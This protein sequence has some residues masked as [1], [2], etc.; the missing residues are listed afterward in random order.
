MEA[1]EDFEGLSQER[2]SERI[3]DQVVDVPV[4]QIMPEISEVSAPAPVI[5][6]ITP[7]P[8]VTHVAPSEH[9]SPTAVATG[10]SSDTTGP[11]M[12]YHC[13]GRTD[14]CRGGDPEHS[15]CTSLC[16]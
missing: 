16:R 6:H 2:M 7:A 5:E 14:R 9:F 1:D 10:A 13:C 3:G 8:S 11:A 12:R 15:I 4:P